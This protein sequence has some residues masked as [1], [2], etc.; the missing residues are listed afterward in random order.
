MAFSD[1]LV[2]LTDL[3]RL[4]ISHNKLSTFISESN[5]SFPIKLTHLYTNN[6]NIHHLSSVTFSNLTVI[7]LIDLRNNTIESFDLNLLDKIKE[8]L[9]FYITGK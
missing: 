9:E 5:T 6:N 7:K 1:V 4:D 3:E 2:N 8:G